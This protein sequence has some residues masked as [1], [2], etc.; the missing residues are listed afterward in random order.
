MNGPF[1]GLSWNQYTVPL[2]PSDNDPFNGAN[3][4]A[5]TFGR[6]EGVTAWGNLGKFQYAVGIF[7]GY[8]GDANQSDDPLFATRLAYNFLD[9]EQNPAY[10]TS[11]T[12]FG[13]AGDI[14]TLGFAAQYQGDGYGTAAQSGSFTGYVFDGLFEKPLANGAAITIEGEYKD[15]EVDTQAA[16]PDFPMYDG[17][18]YFGT[19]AY[20]IGGTT[21]MGKY[22]PYLRFTSNDPSVGDSSSLTEIGVNYIIDG[23]NLRMNLNYTTGDANLTGVKAPEDIDTILFGL[24]YQI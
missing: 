16:T 9:K 4:V 14:L 21:G 1:Y 23:H 7:E 8:T 15:F 20:L 5:G 6:D 10:F 19:V 24:Q 2:F 18:S 13:K 3:G 11:S 12:Y 22:Q 17:K